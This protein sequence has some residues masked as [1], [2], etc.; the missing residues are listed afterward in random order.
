MRP[1]LGERMPEN[2]ERLGGGLMNDNFR[3]SSRGESW[4]LRI[5]AQGAEVCAKEVAVL[6][7]V[8]DHVAV[9]K[10]VHVDL[11]SACTIAPF[12][13][14]ERMVSALH[15]ASS[16]MEIGRAAGDA[17][18]RIHHFSFNHTGFFDAELQI[19]EPMDGVGE[20]WRSHLATC[21]F[22][23]RSGA[24]LGEDLLAS[25]WRFVGE[26]G[27]R[28]DALDGDYRLLH[29]D[30]KPTNLLIADGLI[31]AVLDWEFA[32][33]G[34]KLFDIGQLFRWAHRYPPDFASGFEAAYRNHQD[35]P[36]DWRELAAMLDLLNL[37][38]FL[39]DAEERP[40][41]F[42]DA[43]ALVVRALR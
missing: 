5:Y 39:D 20:A 13:D 35:L 1:V 11:G 12:I 28:M 15:R 18:G 38:G 23:G 9:A 43:K 8:G 10:P 40:V 26:H 16:A 27:A 4:V 19:P 30:F 29:A 33:S 41:L 7:M 22:E 17:L 21:L 32:W 14:G 34:S 3:F 42:E 6:E 37:V 24:R 31:T 36:A 25:T 2:V